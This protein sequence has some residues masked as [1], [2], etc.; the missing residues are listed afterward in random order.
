[1]RS[2]PHG[3]HLVK[4]GERESQTMSSPA[5]TPSERTATT[6]STQRRLEHRW[7]V[8]RPM[9]TGGGAVELWTWEGAGV[10]SRKVI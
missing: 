4:S 8:A 3:E 5:L 2:L 9:S 7:A 10:Q 1:M 6:T